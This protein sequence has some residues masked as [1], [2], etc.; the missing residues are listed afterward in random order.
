MCPETCNRCQVCRVS[1]SFFTTEENVNTPCNHRG[2][3]CRRVTPDL[4]RSPD[5]YLCL[6]EGCVGLSRTQELV[7]EK[8]CSRS[9]ST[10]SVNQKRINWYGACS[11]TIVRAA[12]DCQKRGVPY[13]GNSAQV[14]AAP[15]HA[16]LIKP[17]SVEEQL[18][19]DAVEDNVSYSNTV[20]IVNGITWET[21]K[22]PLISRLR[23]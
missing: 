14:G 21:G 17:G 15:H 23:R 2:Y 12:W 11:I 4:E 3:R 6:L 5:V 16:P 20:D 13:V 9:H 7:R 18:V 1:F 8:W 19:A 10:C 22:L